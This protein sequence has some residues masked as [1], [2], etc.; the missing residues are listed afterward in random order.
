M[1]LV[2]SPRIENCI[3][4]TYNFMHYLIGNVKFRINV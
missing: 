2:N 1:H 3:E 4:V